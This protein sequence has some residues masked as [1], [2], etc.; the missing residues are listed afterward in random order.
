MH[1]PSDE[2]A[3]AI[4]SSAAYRNRPDLG[5]VRVLGD[6]R[7]SWLNGQV[8]ND[9]RQIAPGASVHALAVN[10]R[11]KIISEL[12][13]IE[14]EGELLV[15]SPLGTQDALLA[16]FERFIIMEDVTLEPLPEARVLSLEGPR[17][18]ELR[19][20]VTHGGGVVGFAHD[21]LGLGGYS[22]VGTESELKGIREQL[23]S[24]VQE[25]EPQAYEL[26]RLRRAYPRFS[27]DFDEQHY[28]QEAGLKAHV[29][30]SKGCYL[31]QEVVCTLESRGRLS[32]HLWAMRGA[33]GARL[34]PGVPLTL[35]A[36]SG[37]ATAP[38][39]AEGVGSITSAVWDPA[40][41]A[42]IALGY[43]RRT[44]A[45]VGAVLLAGTQP[46]T[47]EKL[48]GEGDAAHASA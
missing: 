19:A 38:T 35:P 23:A 14:R 48:V 43:V 7:V 10:V 34:E 17:S 8:T 45:K 20:L 39:G 11:G 27:V 37:A 36:E 32:K 46:L 16:S 28:P 18:D 47:L 41:G 44:H 6:D 24:H 1:S 15:L 21:A 13:V 3:Q 26:A 33:P 30:F 12:W 4:V 40:L 25:I 9:V 2:S 31:G 22:W 5:A 29:S 42:S